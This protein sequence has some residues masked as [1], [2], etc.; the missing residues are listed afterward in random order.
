MDQLLLTVPLLACP[1]GM[2]LMMLF[3][4][5]GMFGTKKQANPAGSTEDLSSLRADAAQLDSRIA[6][7]ESRGL[8]E[9][10]ER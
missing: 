5:R 9:P 10:V 1:L 6:E 4:G 3:M 2:V 8:S 7:L